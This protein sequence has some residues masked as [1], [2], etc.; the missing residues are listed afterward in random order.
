MFKK[1]VVIKRKVINWPSPDHRII[2]LGVVLL[3]GFVVGCAA[4]NGDSG[5]IKELLSD[6]IIKT[7]QNEKTKAFTYCLCDYALIYCLLPIIIFL[8]G[9]CAV[10]IPIICAGEFALGTAAG[11]VIGSIYSR[12]GSDGLG[13]CALIIIPA[14]AILFAVCINAGVT[15]CTMSADIL[16]R[17]NGKTQGN[18]NLLYAYLKEFAIKIIPL[19]AAI[20]VGSGS[21][22]IFGGLFDFIG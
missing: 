3:C 9:F 5:N 4:I 15:G 21:L 17:I 18:D 2:L 14:A 13:F 10:G 7:A 22:K 11:L 8:L 12:F 6:L 20:T 19:A 16:A 1:S